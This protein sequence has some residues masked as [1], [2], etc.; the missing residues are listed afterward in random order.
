MKATHSNC[1]KLLRDFTTK[2]IWKHVYGRGNTP[3]YGNNVKYWTIRSQVPK[4]F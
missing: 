1:G 2:Y 4:H 3:G